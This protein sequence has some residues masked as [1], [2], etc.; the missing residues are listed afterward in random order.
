MMYVMDLGVLEICSETL[1][2]VKKHSIFF[3]S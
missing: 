2:K 3:G 1:F